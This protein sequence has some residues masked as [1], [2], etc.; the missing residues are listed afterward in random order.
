MHF[1]ARSNKH[2]SS[3]AMAIWSLSTCQRNFAPERLWCQNIRNSSLGW[4]PLANVQNKMSDSE[5]K[6][7]KQGHWNRERTQLEALWQY[8]K[9]ETEAELLPFPSS[10]C[11]AW[12][13]YQM[14]VS[15]AEVVEL[16]QSDVWTKI[17]GI[18]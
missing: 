8:H 12:K 18:S 9:M 5:A 4:I 11:H 15:Q 3:C 10:A 13:S 16:E 2:V 1:A 6:K 14:M 17:C 7:W